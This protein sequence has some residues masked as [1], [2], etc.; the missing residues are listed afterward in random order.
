MARRSNGQSIRTTCGS[1]WGGRVCLRLRHFHAQKFL[2]IRT[3]LP[4]PA[5]G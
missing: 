3:L 2:P 1:G 4:S 5:L